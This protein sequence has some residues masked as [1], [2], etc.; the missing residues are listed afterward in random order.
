MRRSIKMTSGCNSPARRMAA[1]PSAASP[2]SANSSPPSAS[3]VRTPRRMT[4]WSSTTSRRMALISIPGSSPAPA[5]YGRWLLVAGSSVGPFPA[6]ARSRSPDAP[7]EA[8]TLPQAHQ[9][10]MT[11][12]R[13]SFGGIEASTVVADGKDK[14]AIFA[15]TTDRD[16]RRLGMA[17]H[18]A[19]PLGDDPLH[20]LIEGSG[21]LF[22]AIEGNRT[23]KASGSSKALHHGL[24]CHLE[25]TH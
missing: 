12:L 24:N 6:E 20:W 9:P 16:L 25:I 11:C 19:Q 21:K 5:G 13:K 4:W 14:A 17:G 22:D 15:L 2:T 1:A 10:E 7:D 18:I 3:M 23:G 8:D